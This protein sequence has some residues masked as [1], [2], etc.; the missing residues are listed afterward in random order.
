MT[1]VDPRAGSSISLELSN[2][3]SLILETLLYGAFTVLFSSALWVMYD[4][5]ARRGMNMILLSSAAT[6][7]ILA[8]VHLV[9]D[10]ARAA[11]AYVYLE[12]G[13]ADQFYLELSH[14]LEVAK[15]A[16]YGVITLVGDAFVIYR[17]YIVWNRKWWIVPGPALLLIATGVAAFGTTAMFAH[18]DPEDNVFVFASWVTSFIVLTLVT[19][20]LCT[21]L[22]AFRI[23]RIRRGV[24]NN[25][26]LRGAAVPVDS[27]LAMIIESASIYSVSVIVFMVTYITGSNAQYILLDMM[28]P[29]IGITF[30]FIILR[31]SMGIS[32]RAFKEA[33][34]TSTGDH[35][36][37]IR[38]SFGMSGR[39]MAVPTPVA[40]SVSQTV[41]QAFDED[42]DGEIYSP[43]GD[44]STEA[45]SGAGAP[46]A[47]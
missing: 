44:K 41:T 8:T 21:L 5:R 38:R 40:V 6:I 2:F 46:T 12:G 30:T 14:P 24:K 36:L 17:C 23:I 10:I 35:G 27:V 18:S 29:I 28:P 22:I 32:A 20:V 7:W 47:I 26:A 25:A 45:K 43:Y 9:L 19:N 42:V 39:G 33:P 11:K 4:A 3:I 37:G 34:S 16:T 1:L 13:S 15:T 31:V